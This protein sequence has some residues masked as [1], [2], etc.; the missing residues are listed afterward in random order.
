MKRKKKS[1][2]SIYDLNYDVSK[3]KIELSKGSDKNNNNNSMKCC[4]C[5]ETSCQGL[6]VEYVVSGDQ[7]I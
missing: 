7:Y 5:S 4:K 2:G 3:L 6:F 1:H